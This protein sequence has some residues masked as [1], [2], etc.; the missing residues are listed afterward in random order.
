MVLAV[1]DPRV[2]LRY[3]SP[4]LAKW[5]T[6][7]GLG[8]IGEPAHGVWR[9]DEL[10]QFDDS[11]GDSELEHHEVARGRSPVD[12]AA[13]AGRSNPREG[14]SWELARP[15]NPARTDLVVV[16]HKADAQRANDQQGL[17]GDEQEAREELCPIGVGCRV[18]H[19]AE[20]GDQ[21][22]DPRPGAED[23]RHPAIDVHCRFAAHGVDPRA[24]TGSHRSDR[25]AG[26][27]VGVGGSRVAAGHHV[28]TR[29]ALDAARRRAEGGAQG[30]RR[31]GA[32]VARLGRM[33]SPLV[34]PSFR[35]PYGRRAAVSLVMA[36]LLCLLGCFPLL[37]GLAPPAPCIPG[38]ETGCGPEPTFFLQLGGELI[39]SGVVAAVIS[40]W[41]ATYR[42]RLR[43]D[44]PPTWPRP[45]AGWKP[46]ADWEPDPSWPA[47]PED[48]CSGGA[49]DEAALV[50]V[51]AE[52][53]APIVLCAGCG[54]VRVGREAPVARGPIAGPRGSRRSRA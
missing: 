36:G 45:P 46:P 10:R 32:T 3:L 8:F 4:F 48:E 27:P 1:S 37:I 31:Q 53:V 50:G 5:Q 24:T 38:D 23:A 11:I 28:V 12:S 25:G 26:E 22:N 41:F 21:S 18:E 6:Q 2:P 20:S 15:E 49:A 42:S 14:A 34:Y 7:G 43:L 44:F 40:A 39:L 13:V 29:S 16:D 9:T 17:Q 54:G 35:F 30:R 47:V 33:A 52:A 51:M 19:A